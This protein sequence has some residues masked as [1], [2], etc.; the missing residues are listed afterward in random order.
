MTKSTEEGAEGRKSDIF[1]PT[2]AGGA[3]G[4]GRPCE[5]R[6]LRVVGA[7]HERP[8]NGLLRYKWGVPGRGK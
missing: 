4:S 8:E 7:A 1:T 6:G 2:W 3:G 5:A